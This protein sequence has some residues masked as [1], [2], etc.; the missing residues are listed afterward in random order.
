MCGA[1]SG[2]K[3]AAKTAATL[4]TDAAGEAKTVFGAASTV[5]N[6][7]IGGIQRIVKG[8]PSQMGMSAGEFNAQQAAITENTAAIA[9]NLKGAAGSSAAAIGGGNAVTPA[10]GVQAS[11]LA[12]ETAA[13]E[14]GASQ[15]NALVSKNWEIGRQN[16][17]TAVKEEM[18]LP[19]VF[20]P[21]TSSEEAA[22]GASANALK[23]Q[24]EVDKANNWWQ[25]MV[26][27]AIGGL[28]SAA[29]AA[30]T[31]GMGKAASSMSKFSQFA[32]PI[33]GA[34]KTP[35]YMPGGGGSDL[36]ASAPDMT[37]QYNSPAF[38]S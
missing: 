10:G 9:R 29:G 38:P 25:P 12:A 26:T 18:Q 1:S 22:T 28:S 14:F 20:N 24:E 19:N 21:A 27:A 37:G 17:D 11:L 30:L 3:A 16:Y 4:A 36:T 7:L 8:S 6:N 35:S 15:Q 5:F 33:E 32:T 34:L 23:A 13:A 2:L 31:G